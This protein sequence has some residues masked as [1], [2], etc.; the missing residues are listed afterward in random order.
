MIIGSGEA[1][2]A[3]R[4]FLNRLHAATK[5]PV[6]T[7]VDPNPFGV[8]F[9]LF[10]YLDPL[11]C[12]MPIDTNLTKTAPLEKNL[13]NNFLGHNIPSISPH[14]MSRMQLMFCTKASIEALFSVS[15][16]YLAKASAPTQLE[17]P[18]RTEEVSF[19]KRLTLSLLL[20]C[21]G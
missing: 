4:A 17:E 3:T 7:L 5:F 19:Y 6:Y 14:W 1:D 16:F 12:Q 10:M 11:R 20:F 21:V 13:L 18:T 8:Q 9:Y 2:I 15:Y